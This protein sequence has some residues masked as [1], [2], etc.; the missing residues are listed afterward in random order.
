M[1]ETDPTPLRTIFNRSLSIE[2]RPEKLTGDAGV[3]A[4]RELDSLL[5]V[6]AWLASKL[7]DPRDQRFVTHPLVELLRARIYLIAQGHG[8]QDHVDRLRDDPAL[9]LGTSSRRGTTPLESTE[10]RPGGLASQPTQSRLVAAL[11]STENRAVLDEG[12]FEST[13]RHLL[14]MPAELPKTFTIDVDSM[15]VDVH[16]E[17]VGSAYNGY[18]KRRVYHPLV[19]MLSE[20]G[21]W[22]SAELRP[23]NVGT[24]EGAEEHLLNIVNRVQSGLG[25]VASIRGDAGFPAGKLL[26]ALEL[27][28]IPYVFR[29]K[30]NNRLEKIAKPHL[31]RPVG[32]P[33]NSPRTWF[34]E[35]SY[36]AKEWSHPRRIVLV[37]IDEPG[38]LFLRHF[39]LVTNWQPDEYTGEQLLAHY[40]Q[41]GTMEGHIGELSS[42]LAPALSCTSRPKSHV[43]GKTPKTISAPRDGEAANAATFLLYALAYNLS[44][45]LRLI[46]NAERPNCAGSHSADKDT[47]ADGPQIEATDTL[48]DDPQVE[49]TGALVDD[50]Q[51]EA[52]G[53][54]YSLSRIQVTLLRTPARF[55]ISGRRVTMVLANK[56]ADLWRDLWR[57]LQRLQPV[58]VT[59]APT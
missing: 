30:T 57:G 25:R 13:R 11:S 7:I 29:L 15:P 45:S 59:P 55:V 51:V 32:R 22:L 23:G 43:R 58:V 54:G 9:R 44:N 40:R 42:A 56:V 27:K 37:V 4:L 39:F 1:G 47:P 6:I 53:C 26:H 28:E 18:Y 17:Q 12:L 52:C 34:H 20:T 2:G 21:H 50:P 8:A 31:R 24:A 35:L 10:E 46:M 16:G 49:A 38:E 19:T 5:G 48:V 41:R 33:P 36:A 3:V 14:A